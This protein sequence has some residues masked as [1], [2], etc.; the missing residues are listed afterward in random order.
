[1]T[2]W[3]TEIFSIAAPSHSDECQDSVVTATNDFGQYLLC[4]ADGASSSSQAQA[5]SQR[6]T[7]LAR[8]MFLAQPTAP[9]DSADTLTSWLATIMQ[10]VGEA[11]EEWIKELAADIEDYSTTLTIIVLAGD[12]LGISTVGDGFALTVEED[13]ELRV[14]L[15]PERP[16]ALAR[17]SCYMLTDWRE[18]AHVYAYWAPSLV[19]V[20][21]STDGLEKFL[22][23]KAVLQLDGKRVQTLIGVNPFLHDLLTDFASRP[24]P[25]SL[26]RL[27]DPKI[28]TAK[29]DDIGVA[30][31]A[32]R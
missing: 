20:L 25:E 14:L 3:H 31:A 1:M 29:G 19:A 10:E 7:E 4:V 2:T 28:R 11:F 23:F 30:L 12:W 15:P 21:L 26:A 13:V 6:A 18:Q 5:A 27:G 16:T 22:A 9:T 32:R 8:E 17:A 24:G